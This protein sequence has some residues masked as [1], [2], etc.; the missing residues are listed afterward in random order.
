MSLLVIFGAGASYDSDPGD[1]PPEPGDVFTDI[2][3]E[4][5]RPPLADDL[6][7]ERKEFRRALAQ[8]P[9]CTPI[10]PFLR[11]GRGDGSIEQVL[12]QLQQEGMIEGG[13][14][15][16]QQQLAAVRFYL[17]VAIRNTAQAW[18]HRTNGI[19]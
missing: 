14:P 6:F 15:R 17:Q 9:E 12:E 10:V 16:R 11:Y 4:A 18:H 2:R 8:F 13:D 5:L 19:T 1:R 3:D 7:D